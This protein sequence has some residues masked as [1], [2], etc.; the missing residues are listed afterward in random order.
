MVS[1][2]VGYTEISVTTARR[3]SNNEYKTD[4]SPLSVTESYSFTNVAPDLWGRMGDFNASRASD[5]AQIA[6]KV[7]NYV[8]GDEFALSFR[9]YYGVTAR[10]LEDIDDNNDVKFL[11]APSYSRNG[12]TQM[13]PSVG[14]ELSTVRELGVV[15]PM[16]FIYNIDWSAVDTL[17]G[18]S[19]SPAAADRDVLGDAGRFFQIANLTFEDEGGGSAV[20]VG[21][22]GSGITFG[23]AL[24]NGALSCEDVNNSLKLT[25]DLFIADVS[26]PGGTAHPELIGGN[27]VIPDNEADGII[28]GSVWL[29]KP[30]SAPSG[31]GGGGGGESG[32][33]CDSGFA[34]ASA[35]VAAVLMARRTRHKCRK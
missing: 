8:S 5:G 15:L 4:S 13:K 6:F 1:L 9:S 17:L 7:D 2:G 14:I 18:R 22:G 19:A 27:M 16:R 10:Q 25:L 23:D 29:L 26:A 32:G 28:K 12:F 35:L 33:G 20:L 34:A 24:S 31:G 11:S 3:G 21:S 30:A